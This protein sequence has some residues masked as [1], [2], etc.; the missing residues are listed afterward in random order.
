[1][2]TMVTIRINEYSKLSEDK[3]YDENNVLTMTRSSVT[4]V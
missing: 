3:S 4:M 2:M 1:M